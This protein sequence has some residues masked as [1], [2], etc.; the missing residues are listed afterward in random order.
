MEKYG[1]YAFIIGVILAIIVGLI[2]GFAGTDLIS[3]SV[4]SWLAFIFLVIG[5]LVGLLNIKDKEATNFLIAAIALLVASATA[6]W[7]I[8]DNIGV[9]LGTAILA[10]L[11]NIGIFVAPAAVIVALKAVWSMA[12]IA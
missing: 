8:L 7:L 1:E 12:K 9:G 4:A 10:I 11:Q 2:V 5:I 3:G 6:Q